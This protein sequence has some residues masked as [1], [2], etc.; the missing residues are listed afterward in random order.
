MEFKLGL[1]SLAL[2]GD[3]T[4]QLELD[5]K[6]ERYEQMFTQDSLRGKLME[7]EAIQRAE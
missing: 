1:T 2:L 4:S 6:P 7:E 5:L 3:R